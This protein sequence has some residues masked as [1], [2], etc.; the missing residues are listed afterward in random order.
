MAGEEAPLR[1]GLFVGR[2]TVRPGE[3]RLSILMV[4]KVKLA[5]YLATEATKDHA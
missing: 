5:K 3:N 1:N 2:L 4:K